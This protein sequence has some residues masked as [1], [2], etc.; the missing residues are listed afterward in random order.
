MPIDI[1]YSDIFFNVKLNAQQKAR[2]TAGFFH[3]TAVTI[4][5]TRG[6]ICGT[7]PY[8]N[9]PDSREPPLS[10]LHLN[11]SRGLPLHRRKACGRFTHAP[12]ALPRGLM[13]VFRT[14][15]DSRRL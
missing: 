4:A 8:R 15:V 7:E 14:V 9:E 5:L 2:I 1:M 6:L 10:D 11:T 13:A 3:R 12:L